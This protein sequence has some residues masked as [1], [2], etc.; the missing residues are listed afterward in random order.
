MSA[1][2][3]QPPPPGPQYD[4]GPQSYACYRHPDRA[5]AIR[6]QRCGRPVCPECTTDASVGVHCPECL[7]AATQTVRQPRPRRAAVPGVVTSVLAAINIAIWLGITLGGGVRSPLLSFLA[8]HVRPACV[9]GAGAYIGVPEAACLVQGGTYAPGLADGAWWQLLTNAFTHEAPMHLAF[10]ML[11]LVVLGPQLEAIVGRARYLATFFV[12]ALAGSVAVYWLAGTDVVTLGASGAVFGLMG[13]LALLV[14]RLG[15]NV[16]SV[17]VWIG[18]NVAIT[19][20]VPGISWQ[21]HLGG[22]AGGA[23]LGAIML[24]ARRKPWGWAA[25]A[26]FAVLLVALAVARTLTLT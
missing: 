25:I 26:A 15:G 3:A 11:A 6:C 21:G 20:L 7:A 18:L 23:I 4:P 9:T 12:S 19:L 1:V 2:D 22:L 24:G 17:L 10:N 8:L 14:W 5:T 16:Q 13:A